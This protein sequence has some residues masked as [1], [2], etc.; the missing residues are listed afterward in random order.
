MTA[1]PPARVLLFL[2]LLFLPGLSLSQSTDGSQ[3]QRTLRGEVVN[4]VTGQP[5][6]GALVQ[7]GGGHAV[8]TDHDGQFEMNDSGGRDAMT[9]FAT[10][11]GYFESF[12]SGSKAPGEEN[13]P[14]TLKL[15]PEAI[16][17]GAVIDQ[18]GQPLQGMHVQL[19][20]LRVRDGLRRWQGMNSTITN[21]EGEFR[22]AELQPGSYS[23]STE[24]QVDGLPDAASSV[25]FAPVVYPPPSGNEEAAFTLAWGDH[26]EANLTPPAQKLYAVTGHVEG[27]PAQPVQFEA[28]SSSG[29]KISPSVRFNRASGDFRL[30]LP[31]GSYLLKLHS[32]ATRDSLFGDRPIVI[33]EAPLRNI[34]ISLA[35]LATIPIE[36]EYQNVSSTTSQDPQAPQTSFFDLWLEQVDPTGSTNQPHAPPS[37]VRSQG[38]QLMSIPNVAPGRYRLVA[39]PPRPWYLA[40]ATC[41]GLDLTRETID[42]TGSAAGCT[43]HA[44]LR[45]DSASLRWFIDTKNQTNERQS[46]LVYAVPLGILSESGIDM[47]TDF[48][49]G[50]FESLPPGR[51]LVIAFDHQEEMPYREPDELQHYLSLGQEVT[52]GPG[53]KS[54]VQLNVATGEP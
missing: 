52:L 21:V 9:A 45:N 11:P 22:F 16:V 5:I 4:S 40:S 28:E 29:A 8:L 17:S 42:I 33:S 41:G 35:P 1:F 15:D 44:V 12:R 25:A 26:F 38:D 36:A 34:S 14:V 31:S 18:N 7:A 13:H 46:F 48:G 49:E 54:D 19:K 6:P 20:M 32:Y 47:R 2:T 43:I 51:Y 3:P 30:L 37:P 50:T 24:F 27:A 23:L 10:K 53:G 39:R